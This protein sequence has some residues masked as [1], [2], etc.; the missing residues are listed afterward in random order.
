MMDSGEKNRQGISALADGELGD[1]EA[2]KLLARMADKDL[3]ATW[4]L[5]HRIGDVIRTDAM[6]REMS[7]RFTACM[8]ARL[9]AEP[10]LL[11]PKRRLLSRL[12]G[13]P[14]TLAAVAATGFGFFVAPTVFH[15]GGRITS[16]PPALASVSSDGAQLAEANSALLQQSDRLEYI[17]MHHVGHAALYGSVPGA[18]AVLTG[19]VAD[20]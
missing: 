15:E 20:H 14:V 8:A 7:P 3:R 5:Y 2:R 9:D 10:A 12:G 19:S 4:D 6:A 11:A 16:P 13:W 17:R 18:R 1:T